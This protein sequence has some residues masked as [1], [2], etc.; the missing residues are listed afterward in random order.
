MMNAGKQ[1]TDGNNN[2]FNPIAIPA[3]WAGQGEIGH[4]PARRAHAHPKPRVRWSV[5][6]LREVV[7]VCCVRIFRNNWTAT[8]ARS[9]G[10]GGGKTTKE[11]RY[12]ADWVLFFDPIRVVRV[13]VCVWERERKTKN[14]KQDIKTLTSSIFREVSLAGSLMA[15]HGSFLTTN[16][17]VQNRFHLVRA[18][19]VRI[20]EG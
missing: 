11:T 18:R 17:V 9:R 6:P 15:K 16:P 8:A 19:R 14:T 13:C 4:F 1:H 20:A 7:F 10:S 12:L 2:R 5:Q 3:E